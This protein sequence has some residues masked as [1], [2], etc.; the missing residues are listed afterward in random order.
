M[1]LT[2]GAGQEDDSYFQP[3]TEDH[4]YFHTHLRPHLRQHPARQPP[5]KSAN[6]HPYTH[7]GRHLTRQPASTPDDTSDT[8]PGRLSGSANPHPYTHQTT[9]QTAVP[10]ICHPYTAYQ[11]TPQT[12]PCPTAPT[13]ALEVRTP[14]TESLGT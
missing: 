2:S 11:T 9:P 14:I 7:I 6:P 1:I 5:P 13:P 4:P 10:W 8:L 3:R 12:T